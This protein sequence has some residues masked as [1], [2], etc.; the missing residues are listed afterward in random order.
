MRTYTDDGL[1]VKR[2]GSWGF[3]MQGELIDQTAEWWTLP[4]ANIHLAAGRSLEN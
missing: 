2:G 1:M 4:A 3:H